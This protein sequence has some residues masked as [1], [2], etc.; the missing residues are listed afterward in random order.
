MKTSRIEFA[1]ELSNVVVLE[2]ATIDGSVRSN[3]NGHLHFPSEEE[4]GHSRNRILYDPIRPTVDVSA[5]S[6]DY[7]ANHQ[8]TSHG[9]YKRATTGHHSLNKDQNG[10]MMTRHCGGTFTELGGLILSPNY[11]L[12][13]PNM[14]DCLYVIM[15]PASDDNANL[16]VKFTCDDFRLQGT[17]VL[18]YTFQAFISFL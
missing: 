4:D 5:T 7:N 2:L 18:L 14:H 6:H 1:D 10:K 16:T 17:K 8:T 3:T 15:L 13:Y 9:R 11:P 12:Y